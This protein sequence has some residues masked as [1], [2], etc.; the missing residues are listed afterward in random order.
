MIILPFTS[1]DKDELVV[2]IVSITYLDHDHVYVS[3]SSAHHS[4]Y[5]YSSVSDLRGGSE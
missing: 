2:R 3:P 1:D 5:L 4:L